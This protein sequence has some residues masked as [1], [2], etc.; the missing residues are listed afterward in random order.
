LPLA[1]FKTA[2]GKYFPP[3][4]GNPKQ[5]FWPQGGYCFNKMP[6]MQWPKTFSFVR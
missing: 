5:W 1:K 6:A 3:Q 4:A 2:R